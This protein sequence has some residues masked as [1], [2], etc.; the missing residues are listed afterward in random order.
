MHR[1]KER[2]KKGKKRKK[3]RKKETRGKKKE[4]KKKEVQR[5][6]FGKKDLVPFFLPHAHTKEGKSCCL[7]LITCEETCFFSLLFFSFFC[8]FLFLSPYIRFHDRISKKTFD[9]EFGEKKTKKE[10]SAS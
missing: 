6:S 9:K 10:N 7:C 1:K 8:L 3:E 5:M 2:K 4:K